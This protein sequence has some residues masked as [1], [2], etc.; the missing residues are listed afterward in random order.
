M[1][2][3]DEPTHAFNNILKTCGWMTKSGGCKKVQNSLH[4]FKDHFK[5]CL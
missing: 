2:A 3:T 5:S 1:Y 4:G